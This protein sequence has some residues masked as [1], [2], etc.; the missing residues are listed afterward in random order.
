MSLPGS[1]VKGSAALVTLA[2]AGI[3][4]VAALGLGDGDDSGARPLLTATAERRDLRQVLVTR[5]RAEYAPVGVLLSAQSGRVTALH[6]PTG[7]PI[8]AFAPVLS[9]NGRPC[10]AFEGDFPFWRDLSVGS[11]GADVRQ[12]E[13]NLV[14][15][16]FGDIDVDEQF[17]PGTAAAVRAWQASVGVPPDGE[18]LASDAFVGH[19]PA[20]IGTFTIAVGDFVAQ[21]QRLATVVSPE[22]RVVAELSSTQRLRVREGMAVEVEVTATRSRAGGVIASISAAAPAAGGSPGVAPEASFISE[23][24]LAEELPEGAGAELGVTIT[25]AE[26]PGALAVPL[27]AV[28]LD[29]GGEPAVQVVRQSGAIASVQVTTGMADGAFIEIRSGLAEGEVVVL[30]VRR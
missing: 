20:R 3:A 21:G 17:T 12:L 28:V 14:A 22:L 30:G 26:A 7:E 8:A 6:A 23:I 10:V 11:T 2:F 24:E 1:A 15:G 16:G 19:W 13:Q 27:A 18:F 9:I 4:G 25:L 5:G 29:G